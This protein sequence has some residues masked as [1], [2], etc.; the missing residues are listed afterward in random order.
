MAE[1]VF[2]DAIGRLVTLIRRAAHKPKPRKKTRPTTAS[3]EQR[4]DKKKR[5]AQIKRSRQSPSDDAE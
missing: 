4:I 2:E 1:N 5:Q 3:K